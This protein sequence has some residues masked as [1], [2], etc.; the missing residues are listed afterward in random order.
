MYKYKNEKPGSSF[1]HPDTGL[2]MDVKG[3]GDHGRSYP[4]CQWIKKNEKRCG[5]MSQ[6]EIHKLKMLKISKKKKRNERKEKAR[7]NRTIRWKNS[8]FIAATVSYTFFLLC[9]SI[10]VNHHSVEM[11]FRFY[12][13]KE[14]HMVG[15][16]YSEFDWLT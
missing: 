9:F 14:T 4:L 1:I 6:S 8:I 3:Y 13:Q 15:R 11:I 16:D 7:K 12:A 5:K 10:K 2:K